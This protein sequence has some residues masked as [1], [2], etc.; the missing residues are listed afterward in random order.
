MT[1]TKQNPAKAK[2]STMYN[3]DKSK[4]AQQVKPADV[5]QRGAATTKKKKADDSDTE[6]DFDYDDHDEKV[7]NGEI[8]EL[9]AYRAEDYNDGQE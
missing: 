1:K 5:K 7:K 3:G 4:Q 6:M 2:A 8:A 9:D